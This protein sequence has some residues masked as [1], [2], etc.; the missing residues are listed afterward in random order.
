MVHVIPLPRPGRRGSPAIEGAAPM[1]W[2]LDGATVLCGFQTF[3]PC[4]Q[5]HL[6]TTVMISPDEK[7]WRSDLRR[8]S[9]GYNRYN[10]IMAT[11][12]TH[13]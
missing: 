12:T 13:K 3:P 9:R 2:C 1:G 5:A 11:T 4:L 7:N 8:L 10:I 6:M